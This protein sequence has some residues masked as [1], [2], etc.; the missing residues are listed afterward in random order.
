MTGA[1][2]RSA[3]TRAPADVTGVDVG[4]AAWSFG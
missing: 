2:G 4:R 3:F 1:S